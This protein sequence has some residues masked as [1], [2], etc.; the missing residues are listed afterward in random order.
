MRSMVKKIR[1]VKK[2]VNNWK[3]V[4]ILELFVLG[5]FPGILSSLDKPIKYLGIRASQDLAAWY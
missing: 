1:E 2:Q 4:L 5:S 3:F